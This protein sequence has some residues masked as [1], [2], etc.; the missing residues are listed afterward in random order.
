MTLNGVMA[1]TLRY[2]TEFGKLALQKTICGGIY[3]VGVGISPPQLW[4]QIDA[5]AHQ[6]GTVKWLSDALAVTRTCTVPSHYSNTLFF[7]PSTLPYCFLFFTNQTTMY[8]GAF[9][10]INS[11]CLCVY[12]D[13]Q[14]HSKCRQRICSLLWRQNSPQQNMYI[15]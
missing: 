13:K 10:I 12:N 7:L 14:W 11:V 2:L 4:R 3:F 5:T 8:N 1:I 9:L 15:S 6:A